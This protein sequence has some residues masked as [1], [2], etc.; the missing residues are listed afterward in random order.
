VSLDELTVDCRVQRVEGIDHKRVAAMAASFNPMA[1]GTLLVSQRADGSKVVLDGWHRW[2]A[3]RQAGYTGLLNAEVYSGLTI[4]QEAELFLLHNTSKAPSAISRF[5]ARVIMGESVAVDIDMIIR[6]HRWQ[7]TKSAAAGNLT[8]VDAAE[9]VFRNGGGVVADGKH[10]ELL[11]RTLEIVTAA[12]EHDYNAV[13]SP[14]LLGVAQLFGRFGPS[15]DTRK[16]VTEMQATRPGVLLGRARVIR[17]S[18][19]GTLP[20]AAA[21]ILAGMHNKRRKNNLLPEWVWIR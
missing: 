2:D 13:A 15:I 18:Q 10:P 4:E 5:R 8:A 3:A 6:A 7:V 11:D 14:M 20:A 9:R 19:G 17:D 21:K 12:W 16:L 1:L